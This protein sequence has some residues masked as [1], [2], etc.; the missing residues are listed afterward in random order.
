MPS[1]LRPIVFA[2]LP[3]LCTLAAADALHAQESGAFAHG[4]TLTRW[5]LAGEVD[6]LYSRMS[7]T[8]L[9]AVGGREGL[10]RLA[11][12][13]QAQAGSEREVLREEAFREGEHTTYYRVS[14]FEKLPE[15]TARWVWN[16]GE[17]VVGATVTPSPEPAA[18]EYLDYETKARLQ[19]PF[20]SAASGMWYV[21]WGGRDP[22]LN[23]HVSAPDQ[24]F[25]YD[26]VVIRGDSLHSGDGT[27]NEDHYCFG[28]P[29]YAPA[30]GRIVTVVDSVADNSRPGVRNTEIPPGNHVVI[31]HGSGEHSLLAHLR[32]GSVAVSAGDV[33]SRETFWVRVGTAGTARCRTSIIISKRDRRTRTGWA[34][35]RS[36]TRTSQEVA[37]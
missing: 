32:Q 6:S 1:L 30:A 9:N 27:R 34:C 18:S 24:R 20:R 11:H 23:H 33:G 36:S 19:L 13:L 35:R 15:V 31:D 29:V 37:T 25:A 21:A 4:R 17:I 3:L 16:R 2:V 22:V 7:P 8:F 5:L 26:F 28:E 12:R 10:G 14:R